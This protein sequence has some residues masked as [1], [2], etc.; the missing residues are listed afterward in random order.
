MNGY[1]RRFRCWAEILILGISTICL[2]LKFPSAYNSTKISHLWMDTSYFSIHCPSFF[3]AIQ[4]TFPIVA[5]YSLLQ[6]DAVA[7]SKA[8]QKVP[9]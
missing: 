2:R 4:S 3:N 8:E 5:N 1:F 6:K 7:D 9:G